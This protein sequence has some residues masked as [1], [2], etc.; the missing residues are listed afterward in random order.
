VISTSHP[1]RRAICAVLLAPS[2][3]VSTAA[4]AQRHGEAVGPQCDRVI[5]TGGLPD[6]AGVADFSAL[7]A[8]LA[9][10]FAAAG[11][12]PAS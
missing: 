7:A 12:C 6:L 8:A 1:I 11:P 2:I 10:A 9:P 3:A 4:P 5:P